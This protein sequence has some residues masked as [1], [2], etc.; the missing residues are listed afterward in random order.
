M[1]RMVKNRR[2]LLITLVLL[3]ALAAFPFSVRALAGG[4]PR[5]AVLN[6]ARSDASTGPSTEGEPDVGQTGKDVKVPI[7]PAGG[8][9][10][11][12]SSGAVGRQIRWIRWTSGIW[13][14]RN[15]GIGW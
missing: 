8:V 6:S 9:T 4:V 13:M 5:G 7:R 11:G 3:G 2:A 15:L 14:A 10:R 12:G 1:Q